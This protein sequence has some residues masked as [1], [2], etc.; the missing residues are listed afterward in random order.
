MYTQGVFA[1]APNSFNKNDGDLYLIVEAFPALGVRWFSARLTTTTR[2]GSHLFGHKRGLL[3]GWCCGGTAIA[4]PTQLAL[5]CTRECGRKG[6]LHLAWQSGGLSPCGPFVWP[7]PEEAV[8]HGL[9]I[10]V[11]HYGPGPIS[12]RFCAA[13]A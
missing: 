12:C 6:R 7:H 11:D 3:W 1:K 9:V 5:A 8:P 13:P 4:K 2:H 10:V